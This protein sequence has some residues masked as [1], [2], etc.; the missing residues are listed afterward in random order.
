[1]LFIMKRGL[2]IGVVVIVIIAIALGIY[3]YPSGEES[4][5]TPTPSNCASEGEQFSSVYKD[6]YPEHC[7]EGLTEWES[8]M[9]TSMSIGNE[10]YDTMMEGGFPGGTC[11]NCGNGVCEEIEDV[12]NCPEDC[13]AEDSQYVTV[14]DFCNESVGVNTEIADMCK[15]G[16][17]DL[18]LCKLCEW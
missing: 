9:D 6:E 4:E 2:I 16:H 5:P 12:C 17:Y 15:E 18:P 8:G 10:C 11:I 1:M 13:G 3:F 7:C 14:D